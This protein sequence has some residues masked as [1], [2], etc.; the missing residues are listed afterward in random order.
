MGQSNVFGIILSRKKAFIDYKKRIFE[1]WQNQN[2]SK[3]LT[4]DFGQKLVKT[5]NCFFLDKIVK[6][7]VFGNVSNDKPP[8]LDYKNVDF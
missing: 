5:V 4:H 3:G 6:R 1:W 8:T 7:N 2:F